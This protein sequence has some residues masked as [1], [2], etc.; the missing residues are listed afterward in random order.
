MQ[1]GRR[2]EPGSAARPRPHA[3][4][5]ALTRLRGR[6]VTPPGARARRQ[7]GAPCVPALPA[8]SPRRRRSGR[9]LRHRG[10]RARQVQDGFPTD[11]VL[12]GQ[13]RVLAIAFDPATRLV[14]A[15]TTDAYPVIAPGADGR[16]FNFSFP[17][18]I[19]GVSA[20]DAVAV[21]PWRPPARC[22]RPRPARSGRRPQALEPGR[23]PSAAFRAMRVGRAVRALP[24]APCASPVS[25]AAAFLRLLEPAHVLRLP[26]CGSRA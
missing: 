19:P 12:T 18:A 5:R 10:A 25:G 3:S 22:A 21:R 8:C 16:A 24:V 13:G 1:R 7:G 6:G 11:R 14:H 15:N 23:V 17:F 26:S 4:A 9:R 2:E 20:G